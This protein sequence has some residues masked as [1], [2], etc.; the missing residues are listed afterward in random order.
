MCQAQCFIY[1]IIS[2]VKQPRELIIT[3]I[4]NLEMKKQYLQSL[5]NFPKFFFFF[6]KVTFVYNILWVWVHYISTSVYSTASS[7][8]K[9]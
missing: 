5:S 9:I 8:P 3:I 1:I 6:S 7:P 2:S 4:S